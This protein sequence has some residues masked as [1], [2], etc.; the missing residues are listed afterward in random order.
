MLPDS[1][2]APRYVELRKSLLNATALTSGAVVRGT[3]F[4]D[5]KGQ[6]GRSR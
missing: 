6:D 5:G 3:T 2:A 4:I 1:E